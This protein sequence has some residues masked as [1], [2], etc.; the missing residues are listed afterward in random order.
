MRFRIFS[1]L[2]CF[3]LTITNLQ[4]FDF[5]RTSLSERDL[6]GTARYMSMA[7]AFA[8]LGGDVSAV[9]DNAAALG[10]FRRSEL[11]LTA[12]YGINYA[13]VEQKKAVR[14]GMNLN[15]VSWVINFNHSNNPHGYLDN[16]I[17]FQYHR[18]SNFRRH[19]FLSLPRQTT[20]Q[21]DLMADLTNGLTKSSLDNTY[22]WDNYDIGWLSIVGSRAGLI[23]PT[24]EGGD[25]WN[26]ILNYGE[27]VDSE[28]DEYESGYLDYYT[29]AWGANINHQWYIGLAVN[30]SNLNYTKETTYSESFENGGGY[31]LSSYFSAAGLG[32]NV[33][34]GLIYRPLSSLRFAVAY[35]TPTWFS[36]TMRNS[37]SLYSSVTATK[38]NSINDNIYNPDRYS[39][40]MQI[41]VGAAYQLRK[42]ALFSLEYDLQHQAR[43]AIRNRH[44]L[45][46]G[47]EICLNHNWFIRAG[48]ALKSTFNRE[49]EHYQP[50]ITDTRTDTEYRNLLRQHYGSI[51]VGFRNSAFYIDAAYQLQLTEQH[52]Y[53]HYFQ[54]A[55][56]PLRN[57]RHH[58]VLSIGWT[59]RRR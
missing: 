14:H 2:L 47:T 7:G 16:N 38:V 41:T 59:P 13:T 46:F 57:T 43:S 10:V 17:L 48:Y 36:V 25:T 24:T 39:L 20:S 12:S 44:F 33:N 58:I 28:L 53:T 19:T 49:D 56:S 6:L 27:T 15:H 26:S 31:Q 37:C 30:L 35:T 18:L 51:G 3:L 5:D 34:V 9:Q 22:A 54:T 55:A 40:P 45:K 42:W 23:A 11:S 1:I 32:A 29:A 52:L 21:T 8:A 4:A 50:D